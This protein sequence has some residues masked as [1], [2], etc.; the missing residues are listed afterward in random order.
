M[1]DEQPVP[2]GRGAFKYGLTFRWLD[3]RRMT[4]FGL[5]WIGLIAILYLDPVYQAVGS[6]A[7]LWIYNTALLVFALTGVGLALRM[8]GWFERGEKLKAIWGNLGIGLLLWATGE[9]IWDTYQL[10]LHI[11]LSTP[12]IADLSWLIGYFPVIFGLV[13]CF[14]TFRTLPRNLWQL[15]VLGS[16]LVL[17]GLVA[18]FILIPIALNPDPAQPLMTLINLLYPIGDLAVVGASLLIALL[19]MGGMLSVSW[20]YMFAGFMCFAVADLLYLG[21]TWN[22]VYLDDP[23]SAITPLS[24]AYAILYF[25]SYVLLATGFFIQARLYRTL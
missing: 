6:I 8:W 3:S 16:Y 17:I 5:I 24:Y 11:D 15:I 13:L 12:S 7:A 21:G 22:G 9:A 20:M 18:A 1:T 14:A 4:A 23:A 19:L 10:V 25:S 2:T